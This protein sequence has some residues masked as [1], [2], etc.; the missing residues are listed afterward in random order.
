MRAFGN[1]LVA[2]H[3]RIREELD[4]VRDDVDAYLDGG[5]GRP[6]DL[7]DH[8]GLL[9]RADHAPHGRGR[10]CVPGPRRAVLRA[11]ARHRRARAGRDHHIV[12]DGLRNLQRLVDGLEADP[13]PDPARFRSEI[14]TLAALLGTHLTYEERKIVPALD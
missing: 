10:G 14:D 5:A 2:L 9:L 12:A 13:G 6:R 3:I 1:Q 8:C 7:R 11:P 4:E